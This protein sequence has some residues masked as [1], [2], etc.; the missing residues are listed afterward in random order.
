M[1][2]LAEIAITIMIIMLGDKIS[3]KTAAKKSKLHYQ[4]VRSNFYLQVKEIERKLTNNY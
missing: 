4:Y 3:D 1:I 2:N